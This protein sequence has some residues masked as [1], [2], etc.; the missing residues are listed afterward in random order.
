MLKTPSQAAQYVIDTIQKLHPEE[1]LDKEE[2]TDMIEDNVIERLEEHI[3]EEHIQEIRERWDDEEYIM[4]YIEQKVPN[5]YTILNQ[6]A[7]EILANYLS[8]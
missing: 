6:L 1:I 3:S 8:E 5:Y 7:N 2:I 4:S